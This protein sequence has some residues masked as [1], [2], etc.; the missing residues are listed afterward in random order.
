VP[1]ALAVR[2]SAVGEDTAW[3]THA[4]QY[5]TL[6][7]VR[8]E[9]LTE[10]YR[11]VLASAFT[12][13]AVIYRYQHG[14]TCHEAGMAVG[15]LKMLTPRVS[16]VMFTR[17]YQDPG[18]ERLRLS[19]V[20]G[21]ADN[22]VSGRVG[23]GEFVLDPDGADSTDQSWFQP[24]ELSTLASAGKI[25]E[26][27][28]G[29]PQDIEWALDE[30]GLLSVLQSRP[31]VLL[32]S[33]SDDAADMI[34]GEVLIS[35]GQI[36]CPGCGC[37]IVVKVSP[38]RNLPEIADGTVLV[39]QQA[40]PSYAYLFPK[41]AAVVAE[42]G[43]PSCH[44]AILC[45]EAGVPALVGLA[46]A[47]S[48]LGEGQPVFVHAQSRKVYS[49]KP[50]MRA[51]RIQPPS[52]LA[53]SP[54]V[55]QLRRIGC[56]ITP[57]N[58]TDPSLVTFRAERCQT[59]HDLVRFVHEKLY[60]AMFGFGE[61]AARSS[62]RSWKLE[63]KLPLTIL[64]A[65]LGG[66]LVEEPSQG[67]QL[68][69]RHIAST[70]FQ[71]FLAGLLDSRIDW[72][73][74]RNVSGSGFMSVMGEAMLAAPAEA[75][76]L[77]QPSFAVLARQYMNFSARAGYH[78]AVIEAICS[79][80]ENKN[81]IQYRFGGGGAGEERRLRRAAFL[82]Q[83]L[84]SLGFNVQVNSDLVTARYLKLSEPDTLRLLRNLGQLTLCSRQLDMLMDSDDAPRVYAAGFLDNRFEQF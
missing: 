73:K 74:P 76:D 50:G 57:L 18:R 44:L 39:M 60:A 25:L 45:R 75:Q 52:R 81:Y 83:V 46:G 69:E 54:A 43:S 6:L 78:F 3:A 28:F 8:Q 64:V 31:M 33:P 65:D 51:T 62:V 1:V 58:L 59:L 84:S 66:G 70:P 23:A 26:K 10:A 4:G 29:T 9:G 56:R 77:E 36:G 35:G 67:E 27:H 11:R 48:R 63:V 61:Q 24:G 68:L 7:H 22:L 49:A 30:G 34:E 40:S 79:A 42:S 16:G 32:D 53:Q 82:W 17:D 20:Q 72:R 47:S 14:L 80:V 12:P 2:S 41:C 5:L 15:F 55:A 21:V 37:G 71:A 38:E 13:Q 19:V